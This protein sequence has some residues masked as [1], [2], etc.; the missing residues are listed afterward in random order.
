MT[1]TYYLGRV[2]TTDLMNRRKETTLSRLHEEA[3]EIQAMP[4]PFLWSSYEDIERHHPETIEADLKVVPNEFDRQPFFT[5]KDVDTFYRTFNFK[6]VFAS[7]AG[8]EAL[9]AVFKEQGMDTTDYELEIERTNWDTQTL[10]L[11]GF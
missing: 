1:Y 6:P 10:L 2:E 9:I 11:Y 3:G 7:K 5:F 8:M 4:H